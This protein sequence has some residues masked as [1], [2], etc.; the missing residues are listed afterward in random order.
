MQPSIPIRHWLDAGAS[1]HIRAVAPSILNRQEPPTPT[2][3]TPSRVHWDVTTAAQDG[4]EQQMCSPFQGQ[5]PPEDHQ[6]GHGDTQSNGRL[7]PDNPE[8][9]MATV[10]MHFVAVRLQ[11]LHQLM[12]W[13]DS[14]A[15]VIGRFAQNAKGLTTSHMF[16]GTMVQFS[17]PD[18]ADG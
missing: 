6:S 5:Q 13:Y 11:M 14:Q 4:A 12:T 10:C 17:I 3:S 8:G 1:L 18:A 2:T 9:H 7:F 16:A 15:N